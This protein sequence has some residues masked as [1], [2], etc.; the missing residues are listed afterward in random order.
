MNC[1]CQHCAEIRKQHDRA[2]KRQAELYKEKGIYLWDIIAG[3][4]IVE[5]A[6]G[7]AEIN[8]ITEAFQ[9]DVVFSNSKI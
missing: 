1:N 9:V 2:E 8:N 3:A 4:A 5:S 7:K 6:G